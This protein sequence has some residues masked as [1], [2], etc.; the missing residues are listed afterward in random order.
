ML[1]AGTLAPVVPCFIPGTFD[2]LP[3]HKKILRP[4]LVKIAIGPALSFADVP[5]NRDGWSQI[6][7]S[8]ELSV[9]NLVAH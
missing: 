9:R 8:V 4:A 3:A 2:A 1:V 7:E 5:N 6:A